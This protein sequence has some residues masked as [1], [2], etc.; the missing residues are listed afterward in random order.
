MMIEHF[1]SRREQYFKND[2]P[3]VIVSPNTECLKRAL[4]FE[5]GLKKGLN[6]QDISLVGFMSQGTGTGNHSDK[7]QLVPLG[8][9]D[10]RL[11]QP[12]ISCFSI[13]FVDATCYSY[14]IR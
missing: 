13:F 4:K 9:A 10:V 7:Q 6:R 5:I 14:H 2:H 11:A 8:H 3:I 12:L 1:V